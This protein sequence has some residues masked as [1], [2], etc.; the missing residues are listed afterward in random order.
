MLDVKGINVFYG[1]AIHAV[2]DVSL[3]VAAGEIVT[4]IGANGAG[5]ST[6]LKTIVG[7]LRT[8]TG[9]IQFEGESIAADSSASIVTNGIALVPEGRFRHQGNPIGYDRRR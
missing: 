2:R 8:G 5:K 3:S 7:L 4:I 1:G 9:D 6:I